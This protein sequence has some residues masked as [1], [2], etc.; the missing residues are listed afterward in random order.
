MLQLI[1]EERFPVDGIPIDHS[2]FHNHG[3]RVGTTAVPGAFAGKT[4]ISFP[5]ATSH[6]AIARDPYPAPREP[7]WAPMVALRIEVVAKVDPTAALMLTVLEGDGSFRFGINQRA[8]DAQFNGPPGTDTHVRSDGT[9]APDGL[10]HQVPANQWVTLG[11]DHNGYSEM[12]LSI[13]G[14]VVGRTAVS[15]GVPPV[16]AGG[17]TVG[18]RRGGGQPFLGAID[19]LRV[20]RYDPDAIR[21][22]FWCRPFTKKA[23][24]CWEA[25]F[26]AVADWA[27]KH[28]ADL[29]TLRSLIDSRIRAVL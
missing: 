5:A 23:A 24:D 29:A 21:K 4:A 8:L 17:V 9:H 26:R 18:N 25:I 16:Q 11:F 15:A 28:P 6:V 10:F 1:C 27:T 22:E 13:E 14:V 2:L 7:Q 12:Q 19:Q 3:S 20:W